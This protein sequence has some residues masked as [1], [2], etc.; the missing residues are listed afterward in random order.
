ME[1]PYKPSLSY[2]KER[3]M[4]KGLVLR[5]LVAGL[6]FTFLLTAAL[7]AANGQEIS[8]VWVKFTPGGQA[9]VRNALSSVGAQFHYEFDELSAFVV[10][11]PSQAI[12]GL[13][14][15]P[16]VVSIET[17]PLRYPVSAAASTEVYAPAADTTDVN[18]QIV[19]WGIDAVQAR[20]VWDTNLDGV[21]DDGVQAGSGV[22]L[23]IIDTG[24]YSE[25]E[26][27]AGVDLVGGFSQV[28]DN[29]LR[30]GAGHGSHVAGTVA[31]VNNAIGVVGVAPQVGLYIVKIFGDD[32]LWTHS[33]DLVDAIYTC[34]GGGSTVISM[35]LSGPTANSQEEAAFD[36]LYAQGVLS[37]AAASNDG[38]TDYAYPASY[39]SVVSVGALDESLAIADFSNQ[40]D[41]VEISAPG[42][43][44]LSTVP[45]IDL[46]EFTISGMAY[47]ANHIEY[48]ARGS[49]S[50]A[51]VDGGLCTTTGDWAGMI[52]LCSRGDIS[53]YDKVMN[54][55]NSGG[56]G[57]LIYNNEPGNF[58]GTLGDGSSS[59]II[60]LSISQ[61]DGLYLFANELGNIGTIT[62]EY[63][64]P[65]SGYEHY[66]GTSMATPHVS[67]VA[68]LVWSQVP[69]AS[70]TDIR[71]AMT[72]TAL[73]LGDPGRDAAFGFGLVQAADALSYLESQPAAQPM[74]VSVTTDLPQYPTRST[75]TITVTAADG[76]G[77]PISGA[78]VSVNVTAPR[79]PGAGFTGTTDAAGTAVFS[80]TLKNIGG[81]YY[82]DAVMTQIGYLDGSGSAMFTAIK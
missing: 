8:R 64:W 38:T 18:G 65:I 82:V 14:Q 28:D 79:G 5:L 56:T 60:A 74:V 63:I 41:Q 66:D 78:A 62:S 17:D 27:L 47:Q 33:S 6:I 20:D 3:K 52:V 72:A 13:S 75:V 55:Q 59:D 69:A 1:C 32:G 10:S 58:L 48:S 57:A 44:V 70:V 61:E 22:T 76:T 39:D 29:Y 81:T 45:Y 54:V 24:F 37:V 12:S 77:S 21:I 9:A 53:F 23:C 30:D 49:V 67:A 42:V 36:A 50:A 80:Y 2:L 35:S 34:A 46:S 26:D 25:H 7:P 68:A 19:P 73:D 51:L 15:N 31:A 40:N 43:A 16:N 71:A 11:L 4:K